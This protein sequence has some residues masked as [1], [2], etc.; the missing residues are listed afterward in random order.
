MDSSDRS[1]GNISYYQI[2]VIVVV[3]DQCQVEV[4]LAWTLMK[5][6]MMLRS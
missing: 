3:T 1:K 2:V 6:V 5:G 4:E